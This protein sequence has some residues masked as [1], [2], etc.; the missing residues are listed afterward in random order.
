[1]TREAFP[2]RIMTCAD[3]R[4][5]HFLPYLE[6][7]VGRKFGTTPLI[8]DLGLTQDQVAS[9]ASE[10]VRLDVPDHFMENHPQ[11]GFIM[12]TH[13]AACI[14]DCLE[15]S[16]AGCLY[17]D[18]DVL[19]VEGLAA[20][21][22][23][24]ADVAVTPRHPRERTPQHLVNG[25]INA[26]V[27]FFS[28][29]PAAKNLLADW[30]RACDE[31]DRTDQKALSDLLAKFSL[32]GPPSDETH[33]GLR[34]LKLDPRIFNDVR[35]RTGRVLHFKNAGRKERAMDKLRRYRRFEERYP[36]ILARVFQLRRMMELPRGA[37]R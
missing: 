28:G 26:G 29:S 18:A 32:L 14:A 36:G 23:G 12:T 19:F 9:L 30:G 20:T 35:I 4:Y 10:V 37:Y 6:Q 8:Y 5:F 3:A 15:R 27:L 2:F 11:T 25:H 17:V 22:F 21:D 33:N 13:K 31:G 24:D 34:V 16:T 1:M 7:N